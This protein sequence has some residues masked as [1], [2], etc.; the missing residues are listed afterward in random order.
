MKQMLD[1]D[2]KY[3]ISDSIFFNRSLRTSCQI[4][5]YFLHVEKSGGKT[6]VLKKKNVIHDTCT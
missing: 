5:I 6:T 2:E 3:V 1:I 4:F